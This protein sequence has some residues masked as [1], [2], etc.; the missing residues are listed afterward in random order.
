MKTLFK[1]LLL[2]AVLLTLMAALGG[3]MLLHGNSHMQ[4]V[5]NGHELSQEAGFGSLIG[6]GMGLLI[7]GVLLCIVLPLALLLG[8]ALPLLIIGML[9]AAGVAMVLGVGALLGSPL[10]LLALILFLVLR[11]R[12]RACPPPPSAP[13]EP[14]L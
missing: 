7:A 14:R 2:T 8:L 1:A 6:A 5:L 12:Q 9:L 10:I 11:K 13:A 4:V 3:F